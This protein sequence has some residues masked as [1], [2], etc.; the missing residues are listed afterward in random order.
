ME[1]LH[2]LVLNVGEILHKRN[3]EFLK[4]MHSNFKFLF[5][6]LGQNATKI[7]TTSNSDLLETRYLTVTG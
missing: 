6:I 7:Y 4:H 3:Q 2:S 5:S 1:V